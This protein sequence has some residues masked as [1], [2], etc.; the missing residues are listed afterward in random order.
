[1]RSTYAG[2]ASTTERKTSEG[3]AGEVDGVGG[4]LLDLR[5]LLRGDPLGHAAGKAEDGVDDLSAGQGD[6]LPEAAPH[7]DHPQPDLLAHRGDDAEDVAL[8][9]RRL[10]THH[11]VGAAE[12]VEV[13]GVVLGHER[14]VD[15]L[16]DLLRR[17]R[18]IDLVEGVERLGGRHVVRRG[19]HAADAR[20]DLRHVL[21]GAALGELLEAAQLRDLEVGPFHVPRFVEEDVDLAVPLETGDG[22]DGDAAAG[23][24][25]L[26]PLGASAPRL[27]AGY[28]VGHVSGLLRRRRGSS[29]AG[30]AASRPGRSGRRC[31]WGRGCCRERSRWPRRR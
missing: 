31:R 20:G 14:R 24:G 16:P 22:I 9:G 26:G 27:L 29:C 5:L 11:E 25:G 10:G 13:Q 18:G 3:E 1:M 28:L 8:G 7:G 30:A 23:I 6:D 17:R 12:E 15:Q 4:R 21:G 2:L 19:A